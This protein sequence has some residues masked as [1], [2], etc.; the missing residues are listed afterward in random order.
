MSEKRTIRSWIPVILSLLLAAGTLTVFRA[1]GPKEDGSWMTCHWAEQAVFG[2]GIVLVVQ[3]LGLVFLAKLDVR[4]GISF[5]MIPTALL[6]A[7]I[8]GGLIHLCMMNDMRCHTTMR[9]A[10][11]ILSIGIAV[12]ALINILTGNKRQEM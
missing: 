6:A 2:I 7:F 4:R 1:C 9:P 8:P 11:M 10:V 5:A 12:C 3:S